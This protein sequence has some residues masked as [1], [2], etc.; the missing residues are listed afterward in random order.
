MKRNRVVVLVATI[1]GWLAASTPASADI[2][3]FLG[4]AGG[5]SVRQ[6]WGLAA[7]IGFV[8]VGIEFEYGDTSESAE[9]AA[10]RI[11]TGSF[12]LLVQTPMA[13][14]GVQV[15]GTTGAG[16]YHED[17]GALS[18]TNAS[19]N[20]GGGV[21]VNLAGPLRLRFD[22]RYFRFLGAPLGEDNV[23]RFYVGGNLR[24]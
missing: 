4:L 23:H 20:L 8:I 13:V 11:R 14:G 21:K 3:A 9:H 10:P 1:A 7:G 16:G 5:P 2:T 24:F 12:N 19:V 6:S 18:A 22:Y 15:Y 17:M